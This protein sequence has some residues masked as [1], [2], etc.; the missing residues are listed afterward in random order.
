[1]LCLRYVDDLT[2]G[3]IADKLGVSQMQVS[4]LLTR[5]VGQLRR[6]ILA[7]RPPRRNRVHPQWTP[8]PVRAVG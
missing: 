6:H 7:E 5:A 1:V 4:R 8:E 3:E 2:Q